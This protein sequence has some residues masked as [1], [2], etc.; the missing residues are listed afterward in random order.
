MNALEKYGRD[1][2]KVQKKIKTRSLLQIRSH[3]QKVF[4]NMSENDIVAFIGNDKELE[5]SPCEIKE[6][7]IRKTVSTRKN[8]EK[9]KEKLQ[10][11]TDEVSPYK[12]GEPS[13]LVEKFNDNQH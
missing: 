12:N 3:A 5:N 1:W 9:N 6:N 4:L 11:E 8:F 2:A 10:S 7:H 13:L